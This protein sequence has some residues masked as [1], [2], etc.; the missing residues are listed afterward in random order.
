MREEQ[1]HEYRQ[2][3]TAKGVSKAHQ[4]AHIHAARLFDSQGGL[5][6]EAMTKFIRDEA[7]RGAAEARVRNLQAAARHLL[8]FQSERAPLEQIELAK[9]GAALQSAG[10]AASASARPRRASEEH[11]SLF[12]K[13]AGQGVGVEAA[14][15]TSSRDEEPLDLGL[16]LAT[17]PPLGGASSSFEVDRS[18]VA[19]RPQ[20]AS[21]APR[22]PEVVELEDASECVCSNR[23]PKIL[24]TTI[25]TSVIVVALP[26][27]YWALRFLYDKNFARM[28]EAGVVAVIGLGFVV[29]GRLHCDTCDGGVDRDALTSKQRRSVRWERG[30]LGVFCVLLLAISFHYK[31]KW[32]EKRKWDNM[33]EADW[34]EYDRLEEERH[35]ELLDMG[36]AFDDDEGVYYDPET[37]EILWDE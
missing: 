22:A 3:L 30:V 17:P 31:G 9:P 10:V 19:P 36:Y 12:P 5:S 7:G 6:R 27:F 23:E 21:V 18:P 15:E 25:A 16:D 26:L 20:R 28:I 29:F 24:D 11:A 37:G 13:P 2:W 33:T 14:A 4:D 32:D 8:A 34:A 35:Q 1:Q